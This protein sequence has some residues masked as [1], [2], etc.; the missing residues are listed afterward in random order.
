LR[1]SQISVSQLFLKL[2]RKN[3]VNFALKMSL[4]NDISNGVSKDVTNGQTNDNDNDLTNGVTNGAN[5][6]FDSKY[7]SFEFAT[8]A[9]RAGQEPSQWTSRAVVPPISMSTTFEQY[10]PAETAVSHSLL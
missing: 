9:I 1:T 7:S 2:F 8:R 6:G 3:T 5:V 4:T 10:S